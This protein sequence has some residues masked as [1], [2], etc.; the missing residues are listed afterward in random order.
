WSSDVC[1][2]DLFSL[3]EQLY[4][5]YEGVSETARRIFLELTSSDPRGL[6]VTD[7]LSGFPGTPNE[8][9][10][11]LGELYNASLIYHYGDGRIGVLRLLRDIATHRVDRLTEALVSNEK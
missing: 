11:A 8:F 10:Q 7:L 5:C 2:S 3:R 4:R 6:Q 9:D 1:S